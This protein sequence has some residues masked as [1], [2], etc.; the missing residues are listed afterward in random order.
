[1]AVVIDARG[2][3][4]F[5]GHHPATPDGAPCRFAMR[6][7]GR[8]MAVYGETASDLLSVLL[9]EAYADAPAD[10]RLRLRAEHAVQVASDVQGR[11]VA[12]GVHPACKQTLSAPKDVPVPVST[13]SSPVPLVLVDLVYAPHTQTPAPTG[14]VMWLRPSGEVEYVQ[15]LADA[16]LL[17]F[18]ANI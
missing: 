11:M 12:R 4:L 18:A 6:L 14:R 8:K 15:S 17:E 5:R 13:W 1:M 3:Q 7:A 16:G 9:G 10:E 2:R